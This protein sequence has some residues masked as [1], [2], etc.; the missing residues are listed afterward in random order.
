MIKM[1]FLRLPV[2]AISGISVMRIA[3]GQNVQSAGEI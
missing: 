3:L 2:G 1:L